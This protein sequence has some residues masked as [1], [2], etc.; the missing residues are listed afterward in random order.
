MNETYELTVARQFADQHTD[1]NK[2]SGQAVSLLEFVQDHHP[3]AKELVKHVFVFFKIYSS[4]IDIGCRY[5]ASDVCQSFVA[6]QHEYEELPD[7]ACQGLDKSGVENIRDIFCNHF[8]LEPAT[9]Q[10]LNGYL[11]DIKKRN[12]SFKTLQGKCPLL[13]EKHDT[14]ANCIN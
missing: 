9:L 4:S 3:R 12:A 1:F 14:M 6:S 7:R 10:K 2:Q 5:V 8:Q 13:S 11:R